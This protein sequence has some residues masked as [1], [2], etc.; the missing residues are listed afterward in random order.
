FG[1]A[2]F[3]AACLTHSDLALARL[4]PFWPSDGTPS[5]ASPPTVSAPEIGAATAIVE[6]LG[7][8]AEHL[9]QNRA[10][11]AVRW[12]TVDPRDLR[13][14][15]RQGLM[16]TCFG[17]T[18]GVN[19]SDGRVLA[20]PLPYLAEA[21]ESAIGTLAALATTLDPAVAERWLR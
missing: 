10:S 19:A 9:D 8:D 13:A 14:R 20:L 18:V 5:I 15:R 2:D 11:T 21:W 12:A 6:W 16:D 3:V 7:L 4:S 1:L 17:T